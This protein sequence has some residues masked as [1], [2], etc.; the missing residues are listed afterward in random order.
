MK[1]KKSTKHKRTPTHA[2]GSILKLSGTRVRDKVKCNYTS[3]G[4]WLMSSV[5]LTFHGNEDHI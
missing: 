2:H 3:I 5:V 4:E 1:T